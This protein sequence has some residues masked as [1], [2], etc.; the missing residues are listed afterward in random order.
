MA[1]GNI[2][3]KGKFFYFK[4]RVQK[5]GM[6]NEDDIS[7]PIQKC[8]RVHIEMKTGTSVNIDSKSKIIFRLNVQRL[9]QVIPKASR[10]SLTKSSHKKCS[11]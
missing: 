10:V 8:M 5:E 1:V 7:P 6:V 4:K 2:A 3:V 11:H 9:L